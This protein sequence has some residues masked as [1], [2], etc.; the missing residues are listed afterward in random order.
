MRR[1]PHDEFDRK[2][3]S[4]CHEYKPLDCFH[5]A[6]GNAD[7]YSDKC[8]ACRSIAKHPEEIQYRQQQLERGLRRCARCEEWKPLS[9]FY[10]VKSVNRYDSYCKDCSR[11]LASQFRERT[12]YNW[13]YYQANRRRER[14]R[15]RKWQREHP[16]HK[17]A[18]KQ[19]RRARIRENGGSFT[20]DEWLALKQ[21][22]GNR[23]LCCGKEEPEISLEPD[24][25]VPVSNGGSGNIDNIQPLCRSCNASKNNKLIDYR[26]EA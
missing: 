9:A 14:G 6:K 7:G 15:S 1:I 26:G 5:K 19:N 18:W 22:Y 8:R 21:R 2:R 16:A 12:G 24:H 23:C 11:S 3:C 25:I 4:R 17:L 10:F 13:R 20:A